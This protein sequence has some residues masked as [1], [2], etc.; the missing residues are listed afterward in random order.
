MTWWRQYKTAAESVFPQGAPSNGGELA[1]QTYDALR[2][3]P[4]GLTLKN[5]EYPI[6]RVFAS[7]PGDAKLD[8]TMKKPSKK[9]TA[10]EEEKTV[11]EEDHPYDVDPHPLAAL[12]MDNFKSLSREIGLQ[13]FCGDVQRKEV[14]HVKRSAGSVSLDMRKSKRAREEPQE[15]VEMDDYTAASA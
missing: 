2:N 10:D 13:W 1:L 4:G 3:I 9:N 15:D 12:H 7:W 6:L 8:R 14:I 5:A 11:D